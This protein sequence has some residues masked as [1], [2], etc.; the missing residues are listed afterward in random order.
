VIDKEGMGNKAVVEMDSLC[1]QMWFDI[2][3]QSF[4]AAK[5][6]AVDY[7]DHNLVDIVPRGLLR[8]VEE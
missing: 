5:E 1:D 6:A 2:N 3:N 8:F 4:D 7:S